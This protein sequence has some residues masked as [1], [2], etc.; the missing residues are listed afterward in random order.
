MKGG[1][2]D[3]MKK[4]TAAAIVT[5]VAFATMAFGVSAQSPSPS[6]SATP[7]ATAPSGAPSTGFGVR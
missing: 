4:L 7:M 6:P 3:S 1:D 2:V 5:A